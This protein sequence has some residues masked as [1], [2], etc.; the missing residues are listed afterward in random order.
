MKASGNRHLSDGVKI[1]LNFLKLKKPEL[2]N[3]SSLFWN[4]YEG[5]EERRRLNNGRREEK[6]T[7]TAQSVMRRHVW[8]VK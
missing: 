5:I 4:E 3:D 6:Q 8:S 1:K 7:G 2:D